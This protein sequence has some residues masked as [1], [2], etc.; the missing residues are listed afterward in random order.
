MVRPLVVV[1]VSAQTSQ[2]KRHVKSTEKVKG[3]VFTKEA[4]IHYSAVALLD[5]IDGYSRE[6]IAVM[7]N[8]NNNF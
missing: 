1:N 6:S 7:H 5:P 8:N 2:V 4:P 3:G